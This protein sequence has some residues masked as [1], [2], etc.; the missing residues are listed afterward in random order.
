MKNQVSLGGSWTNT[1]PAVG[2]APK[3]CAECNGRELLSSHGDPFH[4]KYQIRSRSKKNVV[5]AKLFAPKF[6][7]ECTGRELHSSHGDPFREKPKIRPRSKK[8]SSSHS[9][10]HRNS[11]QN[12]PVESSTALTATLFVNFLI[13]VKNANI[14]GWCQQP[15]KCTGGV[16]WVIC[17]SLR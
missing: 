1:D 6:C 3:F 5:I 8:M 7:A 10:S 9:C 15:R 16:G 17:L 12:A 11:V 4:E 13:F 14:R 2:F